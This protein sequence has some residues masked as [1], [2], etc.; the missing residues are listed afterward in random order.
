MPKR[1]REDG[2]ETS[3]AQKRLVQKRLKLGVSK[4]GHAF[5]VCKGFE[6]QKLGRRQKN[7]VSEKSDKD[8]ARIDT[9]IAA[10]KVSVSRNQ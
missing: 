7:A 3:S 5:K 2:D 9:E 1:K 8:V 6:R 10:L 4:L